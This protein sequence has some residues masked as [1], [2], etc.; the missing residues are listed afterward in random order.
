VTLPAA[1]NQGRE[2]P[3]VVR[4]QTSYGELV[5]ALRSVNRAV[6][7]VRVMRRLSWL[8]IA[9]ITVLVVADILTPRDAVGILFVPALILLLFWALPFQLAW[10]TRR[11]SPYWKGE[12]IFEFSRSGI[13]AGSVSSDSVTD[14]AAVMRTGEDRRFFLFFSSD[15]GAQ[16]VP[17][18]ALSPEQQDALRD[19]LTAYAGKP[20]APAVARPIATAPAVVEVRFELEPAEL[21][22][23]GVLAARKEGGVWISVAVM[24]GIVLWSTGPTTYAQWQRGGWSAVSIP[25]LLLGLSPLLIILLAVP[26]SARWAARRQLRTG[27]SSRGLQEIGVA[28]WG[29]RVAGPM[30]TGELRWAAFMKATETEE[31]FLFFLSKLQPLFLPKRLLTAADTR[32]VRSVVSS[33]LGSKA[34]LLRRDD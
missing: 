18:R 5:A 13:R 16:F 33:G 7:R 17:K 22:R 28:D 4:F 27:P 31:F 21:A 19:L 9:V 29:I 15:Q 26:L 2:T 20:S 25:L 3:V 10:M 23:V 1:D 11:N 14:W 8:A 6:P 30:F 32:V 24:T 12:Q 34:E